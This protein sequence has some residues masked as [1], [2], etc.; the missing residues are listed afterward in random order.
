VERR[1]YRL[2][3][4]PRF[5][6]RQPNPIF[7][8]QSEAVQILPELFISGI[9]RAI[10]LTRTSLTGVSWLLPASRGYSVLFL[11]SNRRERN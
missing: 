6:S 4:G 1:P 3:S 5:S 8:R 11:N 2:R 7:S 9:E 10:D